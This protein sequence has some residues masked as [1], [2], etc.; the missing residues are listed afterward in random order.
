MRAILATSW[1]STAI[2]PKSPPKTRTMIKISRIGP[3]SSCP[4]LEAL[5]PA[6]AGAPSNAR[7][8]PLQAEVRVRAGA[9]CSFPDDMVSPREHRRRDRQPEGLGRLEVDHQ[10]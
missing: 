1:A 2:G 7:C 8:Q 3:T 4:V 10:L 6:S 9:A 5:T